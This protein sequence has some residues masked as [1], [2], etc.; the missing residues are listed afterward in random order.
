MDT[1]LTND[2]IKIFIDKVLLGTVAAL[3]GFCLAKILENHRSRNVYYQALALQRVETCRTLAS[4]ICEQHDALLDTFDTVSSLRDNSGNN[5][6]APDLERANSSF[7]DFLRNKRSLV[8]LAV[9]MPPE[10]MQAYNKYSDD[11]QVVG[12]LIG[13]IIDGQEENVE[14]DRDRLD[15]ALLEFLATCYRAITSDPLIRYK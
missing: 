2:I 4:K 12:N 14:P 7:K 10:V 3:F 8:P 15:T 1:S 5:V 11:T 9:M 13:R 6:S